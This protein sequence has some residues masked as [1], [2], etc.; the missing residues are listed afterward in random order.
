[1]NAQD[2]RIARRHWLVSLGRYATL[3]G[4]SVFAWNLVTR[5]QG[6]CFRVTLPCQDCG[7]L[8]QCRLPNAASARQQGRPSGVKS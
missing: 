1:M 2:K 3:A 4:I 7:L 6:R 8:A 5:S